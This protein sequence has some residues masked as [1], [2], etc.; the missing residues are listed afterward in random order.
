MVVVGT[1]HL[2]SFIRKHPECAQELAEL[3]RDIEASS[4]ATPNA[5]KD[6]Y[7]SSKIIDGRLV[8]FKVRGNR[9][10]LTARVAYN[11]QVLVVL[12]METHAEY[13]QRRLR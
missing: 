11:T 13:D 2:E 3:V 5:L 9:Y 8:V 1:I 12:A 6:R 4:F 7:P 10:R